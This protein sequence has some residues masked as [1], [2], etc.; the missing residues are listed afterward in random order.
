M[1]KYLRGVICILYSLAKFSIIK[2]LC[3]KNIKFT[4]LNL[5]SPF[6][7]IEIGKNSNLVLGKMVRMRSGSKIRIRKGAE[8]Y[9]SANTSLNHNCMF[10]AHEKILVGE[11][12]QFGPNV[13][14]YD[15][16]HDFREKDGMKNLKYKTAPIEIGNNVW[17]GANVVIL[18]GTQIGP[19]SV[20]AAGTILTGGKYGAHSLIYSEN[21]IKEKII[22]RSLKNEKKYEC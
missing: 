14:I 13:L 18:R 6:T 10:T 11:N 21:K 12:V 15:H 5:I 9:I 20:V 4:F 1:K 7:E 17:I 16:D 3:F 19:N 2:F 22:E 8:I